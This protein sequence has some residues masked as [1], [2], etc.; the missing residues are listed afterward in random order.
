M[1]KEV[2]GF[3]RVAVVK[4]EEVGE[5]LALFEGND[6]KQ[7]IAREGEIQSGLGSSV[8][9]AVFLPGAGITFVVVAIL[10]APVFTDSPGGAGFFC[11]SK[12][13][14]KDAGMAFESLGF[15]LFAP[16]ALHGDRRA[17]AGQSRGDGRD[18]FHGGFTRVD[19]PVLAFGAQVKKGESAKAPVA[20]SSRFGVFS[21]V[22][23]R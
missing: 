4:L 13:G 9:M 3:G 15:F 20:A 12:A 5:R 8:T 16:V 7:G 19:A 18:C 10:D 2:Q 11:H 1:K 23:M 21:L 22:P 6:R 14:E 17:S